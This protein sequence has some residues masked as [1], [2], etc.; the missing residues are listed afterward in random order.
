MERALI[1]VEP[2][3]QGWQVHIAGYEVVRNID[4]FSAIQRATERARDCY[5]SIGVPSG[6]RVRMLC[7]DNVMVG[8]CG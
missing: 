2:D 7:G 4:K 3:V 1:A 6:V 8:I 5:E